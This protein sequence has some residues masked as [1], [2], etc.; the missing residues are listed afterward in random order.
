MSVESKALSATIVRS[1]VTL[2]EI[3]VPQERV[4][5]RMQHKEVDP[6]PKDVSIVWAR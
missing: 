6:P 3:V 4:H 1:W 2:P 5:Q